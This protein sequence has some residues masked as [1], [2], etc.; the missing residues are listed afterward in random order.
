MPIA[1]VLADAANGSRPITVESLEFT[2]S[3]AL[4]GT[5]REIHDDLTLIAEDLDHYVTAAV[6]RASRLI[7][8]DVLPNP[9]TPE[10]RLPDVEAANLTGATARLAGGRDGIAAIRAR[11]FLDA[12]AV[13]R[14]VD[15]IA[16][17]AA[18]DLMIESRPPV[19][20]ASRPEPVPDPCRLDPPLLPPAPPPQSVLAEQ[21][22]TLA[23]DEIERVQQAMLLQCE[24]KMDRFAVLDAPAAADQFFLSSSELATPIR[25]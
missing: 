6:A 3:V 15:E 5:L 22:P 4:D 25:Q 11:Q 23:L 7:E 8:V 17:L 1:F 24:K 9:G 13:E 20:S 12:L 21:A 19:L 16:I 10:Q 18:P 2:L 14:D